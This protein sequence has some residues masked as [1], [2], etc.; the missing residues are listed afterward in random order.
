MERIPDDPDRRGAVAIV[1]REGR[2]LVIRRSRSVVAP[3][4]YCFPGG[5][6]E[7]GESEQEAVV[8]EV[9]E[10]IGVKVRPLRRLWQCVT[11]WKVQLAWWLG[12]LCDDAAPVPNPAE[13]ESIHWVTPTEML[14]L[15]DL[16]ESNREFLELVLR[17]DIVLR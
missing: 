15:P 5:G 2:L 14:E 4:T 12:E 7:E 1:L 16:L 13:V 10:E 11:A 3:L 9:R 17:G 8:R 6:I